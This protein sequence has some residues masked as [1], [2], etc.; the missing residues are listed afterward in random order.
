M[1]QNEANH[2]REAQVESSMSH[3]P[4]PRSASDAAVGSRGQLEAL[5][6]ISSAASQRVRRG[7]WVESCWKHSVLATAHELYTIVS[8][9]RSN[10]Q[11]SRLVDVI[12]IRLHLQFCQLAYGCRRMFAFHRLTYVPGH[13]SR[14][15][16]RNAIPTT[17]HPWNVTW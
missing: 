12:R 15:T 7:C 1:T 9:G 17:F 11:V 13:L 4:W 8:A 6:M 5:I 14:R 10:P 3:P 16:R 2:H